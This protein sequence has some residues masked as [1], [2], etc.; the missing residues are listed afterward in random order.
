MHGAA[1]FRIA[2]SCKGVAAGCCPGAGAGAGASCA[3]ATPPASPAS[4][5]HKHIRA[6]FR[7]QV[8]FPTAWEAYHF[9]LSDH[10][11]RLA[12]AD[13]PE[14]ESDSHGLP[15]TSN[16]PDVTTYGSS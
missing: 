16:F 9:Y 14:N 1:T 5:A 2:S 8:R 6:G 15:P 4:A 12:S 3:Q 10:D 7:K 13:L 11:L